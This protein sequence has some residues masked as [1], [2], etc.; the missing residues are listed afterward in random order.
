VFK[1][2]GGRRGILINN[3]HH[4]LAAWP[5]VELDVD[6]SKVVEVSKRTGQ[7]A[8]VIDDSPERR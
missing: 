7:E 4:D 6:P 8:P 2:A 5:T 3:Y 1:H